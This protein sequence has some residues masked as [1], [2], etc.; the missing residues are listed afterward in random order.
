MRAGQ[1]D[2]LITLFDGTQGEDAL[3]APVSS[4]VNRG[5]VWASVM[6]IRDSERVQA[7]QVLASKSSRFQVRYSAL[8]ASINPLWSIVFDGDTYE[9]DATKEIGRRKGIEITATA[10]ADQ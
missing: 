7:G 6:P 1:L 2:R 3:G 10:R 4:A 8:T 5:A 9:V